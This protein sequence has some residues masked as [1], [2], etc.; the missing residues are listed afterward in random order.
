MNTQEVPKKEIS[1]FTE[2]YNVYGYKTEGVTLSDDNKNVILSEDLKNE[3]W[4]AGL[5]FQDD[6][7]NEFHLK[8]VLEEIY[9]KKGLYD[10]KIAKLRDEPFEH[11]RCIL[12]KAK[13]HV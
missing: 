6:G 4:V 7:H 10:F 11:I 3:G 5:I 1:S 2:L 13:N 8:Y 9:K 12:E